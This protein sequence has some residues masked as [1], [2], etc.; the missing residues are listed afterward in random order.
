[1]PIF[2]VKSNNNL[3]SYFSLSK[4]CFS[5][6]PKSR[7]YFNYILSVMLLCL[8]IYSLAVADFL[9]GSIMMVCGA[10]L[11]ALSLSYPKIIMKSFKKTSDAYEAFEMNA[12]FYDDHFKLSY[13]EDDYQYSD[14]TKLKRDDEYFY[15]IIRG[16][17]AVFRKS[18][19]ISG[20]PKDFEKFIKEKTG[21]RMSLV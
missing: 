5:S 15:I 1:M 2:K 13:C 6:L 18:E 10:V 9:W 16:G 20:A 17:H 3:E 21:L 7:M 11:I 4:N 14:I 12:D 19:F 8:G